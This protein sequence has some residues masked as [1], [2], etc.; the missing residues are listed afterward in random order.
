[1]KFIP[2]LLYVFPSKSSIL[3]PWFLAFVFSSILEIVGIGIV[4]PFIGLASNPNLI[5]ENLWIS[6]VY[7]SLK[8]SEI[9]YFVAFL[10][11]VVVVIFLIKSFISWSIQS[12]IFK[13]S[14]LQREKLIARLMHGYLEA[15]YTVYLNKNSAQIIQNILIQT[16]TF[17]DSIINPLLN[18]ASNT[19]A[20]LAIS[21]LLCLVSPLAV[22]SLIFISVPLF[23]L[24]NLFKEKV[25]HW[26][27]ELHEANLGII[28]GVNHSLGGFK[29]TRIIGC[30]SYF[31]GETLHFAHLYAEASL[32]VFA[33]KLCPRFLVEILLVVFVVGFTAISLLLNQDMQKLTPTLSIFAVAS[34]RLIPSFTGVANS[35]NVLR[36]SSYSLGQLYLDLKELETERMEVLSHRRSLAHGQVN[37]FQEAGNHSVQFKKEISLDRLEYRYP[38]ASNNAIDGVFLSIPK[39]QSIAIIGRSGAGKTTLVD[40]VLG[41]L[42]PQ[43]GDIQVDGV[44]IYDNLRSW[45][46][47]VGY[48]P[49]SI[50]LI[51]DTI[52]RNIAFGVPDQLIDVER[53][54][55]AIDAAQLTEVVANL[56]DGIKTRVGERG[57]MLSGGQR[58]RVGI[59]RALYHE[60]EILVLDEATSALDNETESLVT[61]SIKLLSGIKTMIIIAHRLTTVEHC[62]QVYV[63][64]K[65]R[66][67]RSGTYKEVVLGDSSLLSGGALK[68]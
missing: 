10:G 32:R 36:G 19:V 13:F 35:I 11:F 53:L 48:I 59:A 58:Q 44:S 6:K 27:K 50:F 25:K 52:E 62:D 22:L 43:E 1:M 31:A 15:P 45:Q 37:G 64:E 20:I 56:P 24:L 40:V 65:G 29:E 61:E 30:G 42:V 39:G 49:Q 46:D 18:A 34:I 41:L 14:Y 38:S 51:D 12:R 60:R 9:N 55:K 16:S 63:M 68:D 26:G 4:G 8:F 28:R 54:Y 47:L 17:A 23:L 3:V 5:Y 57:V 66:I 2:K 7:D 21:F 33:F 67:V